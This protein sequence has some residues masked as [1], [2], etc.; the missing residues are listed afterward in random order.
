MKKD[1]NDVSTITYIHIS[2]CIPIGDRQSTGY[3]TSGSTFRNFRLKF[4]NVVVCLLY[5][6]QNNA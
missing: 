1:E 4:Y 2:T 5:L 3:V 6:H